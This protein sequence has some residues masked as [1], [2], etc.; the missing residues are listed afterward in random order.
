M[1]LSANDSSAPFFDVYLDGLRLSECLLADEESGEAVCH[2]RTVEGGVA[3]SMGG[4]SFTV[5]RRGKVE[6]R[7]RYE[8]YATFTPEMWNSL[9]AD[10]K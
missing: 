7:P 10:T 3:Y 8:E 4:E 6:I 9:K 2:V 5:T 1:R